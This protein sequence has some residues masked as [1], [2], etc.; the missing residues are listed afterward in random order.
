MNN[1]KPILLIVAPPSDLQIGLQALLTTRLEVDVLVTGEGS[2]AL[3]V[4][5]RHNPALVILD[6]DLPR[7]NVPMIIQHIKSSWPDIRCIVMVNDD[8]ERQ[9]FL[10]TGADLILIK[11]LPGVKLVTEIEEFL[12][13]DEN[14]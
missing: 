4:I 3:K 12:R 1:T 7:N 11:G 9:K 14:I 2:S 8:G 13:P 5:E 10:G 6:H